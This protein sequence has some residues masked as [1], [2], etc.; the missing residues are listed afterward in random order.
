VSQHI[1]VSE[2]PVFKIFAAR[3]TIYL[4]KPGLKVTY[5]YHDGDIIEVRIIAQNASFRGSADVS[6]ATDGLLEAAAGKLPS[7]R[8][9]RN[10]PED[11]LASSSIAKMELAIR[12]SWQRSRETTESRSEDSVQQ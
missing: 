3:H 12:H 11:Q 7:E 1:E 2:N 10:L 8:R 6:V 4:V 9:V 5:L